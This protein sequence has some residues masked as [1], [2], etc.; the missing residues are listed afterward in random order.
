MVYGSG[1]V[2]VYGKNGLSV[3]YVKGVKDVTRQHCPEHV[4]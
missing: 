4:Y 1:H 2:C 3:L